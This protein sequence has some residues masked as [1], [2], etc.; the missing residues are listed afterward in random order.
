[1]L[2]PGD[3]EADAEALLL[4]SGVPLHADI[5]VAAHHGSKTSSTEEF[6]AAVAPRAVLFAAGYRSRF[7]H[8]HPDVVARYH[9]QGARRFDSASDGAIEFRFDAAGWSVSRYRRD[10]GRYW[11]RETCAPVC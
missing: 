6:I 2:L 9:A 1:V 3:I 4:E 11:Q 7:G 8:P 5:L 10:R